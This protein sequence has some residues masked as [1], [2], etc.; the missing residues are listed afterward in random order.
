MTSD[1]DK[2]TPFN[3]NTSFV[4]SPSKDTNHY[5]SGYK[6]LFSYPELVQQLIEGFAPPELAQ[7]M[8][9]STLKQHNGHYITPLFEEKREDLVWSVEVNWGQAR[10]IVYLYLLL[11]FQSKND[12]SMALRILH[13]VA[14]FYSSLLK[15]K[16]TNLKKGLPP[17]FPI[18]LYNGNNRWS[19]KQ[20]IQELIKPQVPEFLRAYQPALR[21]YLIDEGS[22]SD[23]QLQATSN[24]VSGVFGVE[25][26]SRNYQEMQAAVDRLAEIVKQEPNKERIDK[27]IIRWLKRHLHY[28]GDSQNWDHIH[29][30]VE[31]HA[32][33]AENIR[34]WPE[35][36][37]AEGIEQGYQK[38]QAEVQAAEAEKQA[39]EKRLQEMVLNMLQAGLPDSQVMTIAQITADELAA[40]KELQTRH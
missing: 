26:A 32:M 6:E 16:E 29:S 31:D 23:E 4:D 21:Y 33:I 13:Y 20:S 9:F 35:Q 28:L 18:V 2:P 39:A 11:E 36:L 5:D 8:D 12:S 30:L 14:S 40:I 25:K 38:A 27:V 34:K 37:K 17:V 1:A 10:H 15:N 19:A 3:D 22:Y 7:M 24:S